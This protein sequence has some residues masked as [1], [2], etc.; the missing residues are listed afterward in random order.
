MAIPLQ[1]SMPEVYTVAGDSA[2]I[3]G[4]IYRADVNMAVWQ[5]AVSP[6]LN[7]EC[8]ALLKEGRFRGCSLSLPTSQL[9]TLSEAEPVLTAYPALS[10]DI[11]L[12]ADMFSLLFE[13][14]AVGLRLTP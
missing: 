7:A 10:S 8:D 6:A 13:L 12:L 2:E 14:D 1:T 11:Q 9:S 4:D 3:F 5:R